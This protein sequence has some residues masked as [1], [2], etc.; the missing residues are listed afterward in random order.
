MGIGASV[1]YHMDIPTEVSRVRVVFDSDLDR[2][3]LPGDKCERTH[4]MRASVKPDSP[5]M[6]MPKTLAKVFSIE[7]ETEAGWEGVIFETENLRRLVSVPICRAVTG[8]RLTVM[9]TWGAQDVHIM[10]FDFE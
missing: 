7:V 4:N 5:V 9:E 10:S 1:E 3:T 8:I 6:C 2:V